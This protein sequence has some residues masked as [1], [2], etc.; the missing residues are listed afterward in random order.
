MHG[1][2]FTYPPT[3]LPTTYPEHIV[4]LRDG[5]IY[6]GGGG[7]SVKQNLALLLGKWRDSIAQKRVASGSDFGGW[8]CFSSPSLS[9]VSKRLS[10]ACVCGNTT[11]SGSMR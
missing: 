5:G 1:P 4:Y 3:Y 2:F 7:V 6:G 8:L 9:V 11:G 10:F